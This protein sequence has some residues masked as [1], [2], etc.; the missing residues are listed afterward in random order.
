MM[1]RTV[2]IE[3][4]IHSSLIEVTA[5]LFDSTISASAEFA[6][7]VKIYNIDP[8]YYQGP[9][10]V[11]PRAH[12]QTVLET[13]GLMM[14]DDVTVLEVPYFETSNTSGFTA[15]IANEV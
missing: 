11:T 10:T 2:T 3:P 14:T 1:Y 9:Y 5:E 4:V 13:D 6:M 8:E 12:N 15:Y 7:P